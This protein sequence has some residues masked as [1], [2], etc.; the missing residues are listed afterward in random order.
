LHARGGSQAGLADAAFPAEQ[1]NAH[2]SILATWGGRPR[3]ASTP[4]AGL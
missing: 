3:Q 1:Q 2:L 4:A